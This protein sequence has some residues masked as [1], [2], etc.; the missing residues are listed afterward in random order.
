MNRP[1]RSR[2][3]KL[4]RGNFAF[5][6]ETLLLK[7]R[8][9]RER[10][11]VVGESDGATGFLP[12]AVISVD[13]GTVNFVVARVVLFPNPRYGAPWKV[14][15]TH[16]AKLDL[17]EGDSKLPIH[18]IVQNLVVQLADLD[19]AWVWENP[20]EPFL[21]EVQM[22]QHEQNRY[23]APRSKGTKKRKGSHGG[24]DDDDDSND[25]EDG[26]EGQRFRPPE[27]YGIAC[28]LAAIEFSRKKQV[29]HIGP[30]VFKALPPELY[31]GALEQRSTF[32]PVSGKLKA[33]LRSVH[34]VARKETVGDVAM[35]S[36]REVGFDFAADWIDSIARLKPQQD[37]ADAYLQG[38]AYL[39]NLIEPRLHERVQ[40]GLRRARRNRQ[41]V[42]YTLLE[43]LQREALSY[44]KKRA[45][46]RPRGKAVHDDHEP[47]KSPLTIDLTKFPPEAQETIR[48]FDKDDELLFSFPSQTLPPD[49][50][51]RPD[52]NKHPRKKSSTPALSPQKKRRRLSSKGERDQKKPTKKYEQSNP[53]DFQSRLKPL[54]IV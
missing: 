27:N 49:V 24:D 41:P 45:V 7:E 12:T 37:V 5:C 51:R 30:D 32:T 9:A 33:G 39:E 15:L 35:E 21:V 40:L 20:D 19:L 3:R 31:S 34:G 50:R 16:A 48:A 47:P 4:N 44:S 54:T 13:I 42:T 53:E 38:K 26:R 2:K 29:I 36:L 6:D 1:Q 25:D 14:G 11:C 17:K 52:K 23:R 43:A 18:L 8:G 28:A 10:G 46:K 22:D